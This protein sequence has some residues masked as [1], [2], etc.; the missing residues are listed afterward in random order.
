MSGSRPGGTVNPAPQE[1]PEPEHGERHLY[2][3]QGLTV[4]GAAA[5]LGLS[6]LALLSVD[7]PRGYEERERLAGLIA[8][9]G[10]VAY[11]VGSPGGSLAARASVADAR[12]LGFACGG[13]TPR[14]GAA[15]PARLGLTPV[16][17]S[18]GQPELRVLGTF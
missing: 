4:D 10:A 9:G 3:W 7:V 2:G 11:G 5:A 1:S 8:L 13:D 18:D 14:S 12:Q 15:A 17:S 6:S 16:V